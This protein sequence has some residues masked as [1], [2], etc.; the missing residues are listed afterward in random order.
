[1]TTKRTLLIAQVLITLMMATLMSGI[2]SMIALGPTEL[3]LRVWPRQI[4]IAWPIAFCLTLVVS[5]V[6]FNLARRI[7]SLF[8]T[9]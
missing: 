7:N 2:M 5:R 6:G 4:I 1:M 8:A 3:W 9:P